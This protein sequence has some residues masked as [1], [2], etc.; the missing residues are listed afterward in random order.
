MEKGWKLFYFTGD[1]YRSELAKELIE[2]SSIHAVV[3]N[4]KD[5]SYLVF[6][7]VEVYVSDEDEEEANRILKHLKSGMS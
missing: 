4:C 6:G 1:N 7:N 5:S 3:I 2:E